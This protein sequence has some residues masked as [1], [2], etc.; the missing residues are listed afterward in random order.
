MNKPAFPEFVGHKKKYESILKRY[1]PL[2]GDW[3]KARFDGKEHE[4][5]GLSKEGFASF[6]REGLVNVE[7]SY[8]GPIGEWRLCR[9]D[10]GRNKDGLYEISWE[11]NIKVRQT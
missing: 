1:L 11:L 8:S 5:I 4:D 9:L 7:N 3:F 6:I 2:L 10:T